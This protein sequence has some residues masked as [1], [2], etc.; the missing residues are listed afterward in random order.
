MGNYFTFDTILQGSILVFCL[1]LG[2]IIFFTDQL[3]ERKGEE[4]S[5]A[6]LSNDLGQALIG[7]F[8]IILG[9][10]LFNDIDNSW[11]K[12]SKTI[13]YSVIIVLFSFIAG[14]FANTIGDL[15]MDSH[16]LY[17][18]GNKLLWVDNEEEIDHVSK[19]IRLNSFDDVFEFDLENPENLPGEQK[20]QI[21]YYA[22]HETLKDE[23]FSEYLDKSTHIAEYTEAFALSFYILYVFSWFNLISIQL[24]LFFVDSKYGGLTKQL[25]LYFKQGRITT[26]YRVIFLLAVAILFFGFLGMSNAT[27][28]SW[29]PGS[30][31]FTIC[32][33]FNSIPVVLW[34]YL[35][36]KSG[37]PKEH[38]FYRIPFPEKPT[39][40]YRTLFM[41]N[42]FT[43]IFLYSGLI[44]YFISGITWKASEKNRNNI[45]Y[46]LYKNI[47][48]V[49]HQNY[50]TMIH[51]LF[52]KTSDSTKK[53]TIVVP[54]DTIV[55]NFK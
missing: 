16:N 8:K 52:D 19:E 53:E 36:Y 5:L 14:V 23:V 17:H 30:R 51:E 35:W 3:E 11:L 40:T 29:F 20:E 46:G 21:Y 2:C 48:P 50:E 25:C 55:A 28:D 18:L 33:V 9:L 34:L 22:K 41:K 39:I 24:R 13:S 45:T 54:K 7:S 37:L 27:I 49:I 26:I 15:W 44:G 4:S 43:I 6:Q 12:V 47:N 38:K 1:V 42:Y 10:K 32:L 31:R